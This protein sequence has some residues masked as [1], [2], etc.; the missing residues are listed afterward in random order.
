MDNEFYESIIKSQLNYIEHL[1]EVIYL[2]KNNNAD[3]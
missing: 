3:K 2:L 1:E